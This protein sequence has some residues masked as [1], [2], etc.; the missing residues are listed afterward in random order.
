MTRPILLAGVLGGVL[1]GVVAVAAVKLLWSPPVEP[2]KVETNAQTFPIPAEARTIAEG[3]L[4]LLKAGKYDEFPDEVK[5]ART[6]ISDDEFALFRKKFTQS[7]YLYH[8][9][10]GAVTGEYEL[11]REFALRPDLVRFLYL[12]KFER[13]AVAW[14]F[15]LYR[16]KDGWRLNGVVWNE[17]LNNAFP[18]GS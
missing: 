15:V 13:G 11:M 16:T 18:T 8:G 1:G 2:P 3:F 12:E 9:M 10:Y 5:K 7:R 6:S 4:S 17:E 14:V